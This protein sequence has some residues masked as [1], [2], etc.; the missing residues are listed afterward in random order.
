MFNFNFLYNFYITAKAGNIKNA[1]KLLM[2]TQ[3]ALSSDLKALEKSLDRKLIH[4]SGEL[5]KLTEVGLVVYDYCDRIF[6]L[7]EQ[8]SEVLLKDRPSAP[9]SLKIGVQDE[10]A[11]SLAVAALNPL[12]KK[13]KLVQ[14]TKVP[15]INM[16]AGKHEELIDK[17]RVQKLDAL[18]SV[19]AVADSNFINIAHAESPV[20][21]ICSEKVKNSSSILSGKKDNL[22]IKEL[23]EFIKKN[24]TSWV[25]PSLKSKLRMELVTFLG[26]NNIN[27]AVLFESNDVS[28]LI[29]SVIDDLGCTFM[30]V[31][32]VT[33]EI[34][35][36]LL[37]AFGPKFGFW[38][39]EIWL[40]CHSQKQRDSQF[41]ALVASFNEACKFWDR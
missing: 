32:F 30:P 35:S 39:H 29:R 16:V 13:H 9:R 37:H 7:T 34:K 5:N 17:L 22:S 40:S 25:M 6:T 26:H 38:K 4:K 33:S 10:I 12:I 14:V 24:E 2:I 31:A 23:K 27:S 11:R 1:A 28:T 41:Q 18:I 3:P 20:V 15:K 21:L 8:M 36:G 19:R